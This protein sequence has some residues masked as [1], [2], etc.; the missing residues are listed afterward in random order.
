MRAFQR[1]RTMASAPVPNKES[2]S[3]LASRI[4]LKGVT[5]L[6]RSDLNTPF[7][8]GDGPVAISDDTRIR[9]SLPTLRLLTD[10]GA[11]VVVCS[12]VGRPK[13]QRV[14]KLSTAPIAA[15]LSELLGK[16]VASVAECNGDAVAAAAARL[17]PGELLL[18]ENLRFHA[19]EEK[20]EPAFAHSIV[21]A[22]GAAVYV[23]DAFGAA[24]R[25]HASTAGVAAHVKHAVAG[26]LMQK[27]LD[28][29]YGA[30]GDPATVKRP[31]AAIVGGSK[32]SSK[33]GVINVLLDK[34]DKVIIGGGMAFTF[35]KARGLPTGDSLVEDDQLELASR[36]EISAKAKGVE[37]LLPVDY[38]VADRFEG[39]EHSAKVVPLDQIPDG[40]LGLDHGPMSCAAIRSAL[41]GCRTVLWNGPMGVFEQPAYAQGTYAVAEQLA[42]LSDA[43]CIT[44][45]GGGDSVAAVN[46]AGLASRMSH[47]STGGG[48]SLELL[49]GKPMPGIIALDDAP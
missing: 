2:V 32:V 24:H 40:W 43:G 17:V 6:V 41:Q 36:L 46:K 29:L 22:C 13:G 19:A 16:A 7:A 49:E 8:K 42:E 1:V 9:E 11:K 31:F 14:D 10:A 20:N 3:S 15:R 27:E 33:I 47:I 25:A 12:H 28:Y 30:L 35:L 39:G 23:N 34:A 18:L 5:C 38:V 21:D 45:I 26:L 4:D 37:L 44:V 48:A